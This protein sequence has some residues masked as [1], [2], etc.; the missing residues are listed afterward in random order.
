MSKTQ[1]KVWARCGG[2]SVLLVLCL[3]ACAPEPIVPVSTPSAL[4]T[5]AA[6]AAPVEIA[7][8]PLTGRAD[9]RGA[10]SSASISAKIDNHPAARPQAALQLSDIVFEELVEGGMTRYLAVWQS[11]IPV[12][13][14]P[15]RSIRPMDPDIISSFGGI[16]AYSG[17]Q[18]RFVAMMQDTA[19]VNAV[20]GQP[21]TE[22]TFYRSADRSAPHNVMV[23]AQEV[24]AEHGDLAAP[25]QQFT[26]AASAAPA[27]AS[28]AG[29][30]TAALSLAFSDSS[31]RGWTWDATTL[32]W[33]RS[34][35]GVA[36]LDTDGISISATNVVT[37]RVPVTVSEDIPKSELIGSGE[38]WVSS[39]GF[40]VHATWSKSTATEP[41][42]LTDDAGAPIRLE[43]GN[44]W[45]ELVPV[46]GSVELVG[47]AP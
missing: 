36:D 33:S 25:A 31:Q 24:L 39:G 26:Y 41:F 45:V 46:A 42:V 22:D 1:Q 34:Q 40:T 5:P 14:G 4:P 32:G 15:V 7:L 17:G 38:A 10:V 28:A 44:T 9:T 19:V 12:E 21:D 18:D 29:A 3:S 35:D 20:H 30:A 13:L 2:L 47:L 16:I 37:L 23:L 27:S 8:A 6:T 11:Q 43:P